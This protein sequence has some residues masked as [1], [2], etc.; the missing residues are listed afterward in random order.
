M[1][2]VAGIVQPTT[3]LDHRQTEELRIDLGEHGDVVGDGAAAFPAIAGVR[4]AHDLLDAIP[5]RQGA[6][7]DLLRHIAPRCRVEH[8]SSSDP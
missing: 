4:V 1:Q 6:G 8:I 5:P 7:G 3:D 2:S